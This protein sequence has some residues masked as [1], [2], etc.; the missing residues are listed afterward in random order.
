[1]AA[2]ASREFNNITKFTYRRDRLSIF[3][4]CVHL[5]LHHES[6]FGKSGIMVW[7]DY[8]LSSFVSIK[9]RK[10]VLL[11]LSLILITVHFT[12]IA[13]RQIIHHHV[14]ILKTN[15][16]T[17]YKRLFIFYRIYSRSFGIYPP[18]PTLTCVTVGLGSPLRMASG[19]IVLFVVDV[20]HLSSRS[21]SEQKT[22][23]RQH[24]HITVT[25]YRMT[26]SEQVTANARTE[27]RLVGHSI[28]LTVPE[29]YACSLTC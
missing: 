17:S 11:N 25:T 5:I 22:A 20:E 3:A 10:Y 9:S 7:N 1:M 23:F 28:E 18:P 4:L 12:K 19:S 15:F 14:S 29:S 6:Y 26:K 8:F 21:S 13:F 16:L 24:M 2:T 27:F